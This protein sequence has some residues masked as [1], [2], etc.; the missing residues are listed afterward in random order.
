MTVRCRILTANKLRKCMMSYVVV[1]LIVMLGL[2]GDS[3]RNL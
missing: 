2:N 1:L 3:R